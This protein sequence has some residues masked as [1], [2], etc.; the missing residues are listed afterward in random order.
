M[1]DEHIKEAKAAFNRL[2][3][4]LITNLFAIPTYDWLARWGFVRPRYDIE[5]AAKRLVEL[6][7]TFG[8]PTEDYQYTHGSLQRV[9]TALKISVR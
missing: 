2:S 1:S 8:D 4:E 3:A 7:I 6:S 5:D 9:Q